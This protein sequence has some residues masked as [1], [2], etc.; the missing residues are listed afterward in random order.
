MTTNT[1][2]NYIGRKIDMSLYPKKSADLPQTMGIGPLSVLSISGPLK[3]AQNYA[4]V[5]L[6]RSGERSEDS[7]FGTD[8]LTDFSSSNLKF[9]MQVLQSFSINSLLAINYLKSKYTADTPPDE[10]IKSARLISYSIIGRTSINLNVE[11]N[12]SS[13]EKLTFLLPVEI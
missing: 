5:I 11:L 1:S 12:I 10:R 8:L 4:R 2:T 6:S 9:P 3:A 13:G 7:G